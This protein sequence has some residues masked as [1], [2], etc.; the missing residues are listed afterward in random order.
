MLTSDLFKAI[1]LV[2]IIFLMLTDALGKCT[3]QCI[4]GKHKLL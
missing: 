3:L 1:F 4:L 2:F